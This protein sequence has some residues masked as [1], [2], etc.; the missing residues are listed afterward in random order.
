M[1]SIF[2]NIIYLPAIIIVAIILF[3][4]GSGCK[5][6]TTCNGVPNVGVNININLSNPSYSSLN[7]VGGNEAVSGGYD[8]ILIYQYQQGVFYAYDCCC[9]Y[10]G[11]S[12]SKAIVTAQKNGIY[13]VCPVCGSSFL[14]S[15]GQP[16]KGPSSCPLKQ[17]NNVSYDQADNYLTVT[18]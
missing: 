10:D 11:Q 13:A 6:E 7:Y 3:L 17:Y 16:N 9:P 1:K 15:S 2:R 4:P 18:N 12:N 14:L 5:K 8:G